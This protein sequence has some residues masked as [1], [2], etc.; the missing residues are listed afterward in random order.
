[1]I[2]LPARGLRARGV[3]AT[4][5][6]A[7]TLLSLWSKIHAGDVALASIGV[8]ALNLGVSLANN[9]TLRV[10]DSIAENGAKLIECRPG[11]EGVLRAALP[12][13]RVVPEVFYEPLSLRLTLESDLE[14]SGAGTD[15]HVQIRSAQGG[16]PVRDV[17]VVGFTNFA[18]REG[19]QAFTDPAGIAMLP[20]ASKPAS[21]ERLYAFAER[22]FWSALRVS[23]STA[24]SLK[25]DLTPIDLSKPHA[26]RHYFGEPALSVGA[27]VSVGVIDTG[28]GPHPDLVI[29]GGFNGVTGQ[30]TTQFGD[31]GDLH[32]TH[33]AGIIG[34]RG[35]APTGTRGVAPGVTLFS[36]RVFAK[37]ANASNFD[38][39]KAIDRARENNCDLINLSLGRPAGG[40]APDETLVRIAL[41]D[42]REAGM[43]PIAAA[44]NDFRKG[45]SFPGAD[46]LC[47]AVSA[48]GDKTVLSPGSVSAAAVAP[49]PGANATEFIADFSN[50]GP[51]IDVAGP[52]VGVVSTVPTR[53]FSVMDG[54]SMAC[55]AV[56]GVA[57]RL[58]AMKPAILGMPRNAGR[59]IAIADLVLA[60]ARTHGFPVSMEGRGMPT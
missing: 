41:E 25:M 23:V 21:F 29:A 55:P 57:A 48:L 7:G 38:I 17:R 46:D 14:P 30:D 34:S 6:A 1:M 53:D 51:E 16:A 15:V 19:A 28:S 39:A 58:L 32:G 20:F 59:A 44:G 36:Y 24:S 33:V 43:L 18:R 31:N 56:T 52:G 3:E 37:G 54:T 26:L 50:V 27:G 47:I 2:V 11:D 35:S 49:P 5:P 45:V 4:S 42:A 8:A 12:G 10:V 22:G 9:T 13:L 60:A 40:V